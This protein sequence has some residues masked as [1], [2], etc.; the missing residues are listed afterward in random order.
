MTLRSLALLLVVGFALASTA[1]CGRKGTPE[2][3]PGTDF[4]RTYPSR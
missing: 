1:G 2:S 3:P 4:P